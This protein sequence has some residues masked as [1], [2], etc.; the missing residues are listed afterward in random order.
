MRSTITVQV[1]TLCV[2]FVQTLVCDELRLMHL[3]AIARKF[4]DAGRHKTIRNQSE[5]ERSLED[6]N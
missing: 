4:N 5:L 2:H 3:S 1:T 6:F